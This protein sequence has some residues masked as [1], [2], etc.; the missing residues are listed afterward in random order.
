[1]PHTNTDRRSQRRIPT[2]LPVSIRSPEGNAE[3]SG[4]TRDLSTS[5]VFLYTDTQIRQ[6]SELELVLILPP[7]LGHGEKQWV[8]CQAVVVRVESPRQAK[9]NQG[10]GV[11]ASIRSME[12][13]P[14][15]AG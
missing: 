3:V 13:L 12:V 10:F 5:G 14:E 7:E 4:H 11:A 15:I 2:R 1:M 8:C 9:A 6:G